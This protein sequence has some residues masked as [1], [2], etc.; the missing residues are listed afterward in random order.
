M[1]KV[2]LILS[3]VLLTLMSVFS[4]KALAQTKEIVILTTAQCGECKEHIEKALMAVK[5]VRFAELDIKTKQAKVVYN[6]KRT[7]PEELRKAISMAGYDADE[8][9]ADPEAVKRLNPCCTKDGH[10][11]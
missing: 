9:P 10:R 1:K 2:S 7:T 11:E 6:E 8:V 5:G 3:V 4:N